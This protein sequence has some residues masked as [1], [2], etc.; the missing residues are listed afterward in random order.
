VAAAGLCTCRTQDV[1]KPS[2]IQWAVCSLRVLRT[3]WVAHGANYGATHML[4]HG[5][6]QAYRHQQH[7]R[8]VPHLATVSV[9]RPSAEG[10]AIFCVVPASWSCAYLGAMRPARRVP[11][12]QRQQYCLVHHVLTCAAF[13]RGEVHPKAEC[14]RGCAHCWC[15]QWNSRLASHTL[16]WCTCNR[17][18]PAGYIHTSP[19]RY[20]VHRMG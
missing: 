4:K 13:K 20:A 8:Q 11:N 7:G 10:K 9:S 14:T 2:E 12:L 15:A 17:R 3:S 5:I 19:A 16:P 18:S 1:I 6:L